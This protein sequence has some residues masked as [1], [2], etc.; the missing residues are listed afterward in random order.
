MVVISRSVH[1][2]DHAPTKPTSSHQCQ[3]PSVT[4]PETIYHGR[5][6]RKKKVTT[7][8]FP[9][10][11]FSKQLQV[12][13]IFLVVFVV[14][15]QLSRKPNSKLFDLT[16][17]PPSLLRTLL[18]D[19]LGDPREPGVEVAVCESRWK[20]FPRIPISCYQISHQSERII[21]LRLLLLGN[22]V[23]IH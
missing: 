21:V 10:K 6:G 7:K 17:P 14:S 4:I 13:P 8:A 23:S 11:V 5:R 3:A 1:T 9:K 20:T 15:G 2:S 12:A 22:E 18:D 16:A 19:H